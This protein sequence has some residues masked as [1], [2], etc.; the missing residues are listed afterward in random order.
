MMCFELYISCPKTPFVTCTRLADNLLR[1]ASLPKPYL[2]FCFRNSYLEKLALP[3]YL[4]NE[5][6]PV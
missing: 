2:T 3:L 4:S 1:M 6:Q 5:V